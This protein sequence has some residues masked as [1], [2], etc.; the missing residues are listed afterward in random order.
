MI[1]KIMVSGYDDS[2]KFPTAAIIPQFRGGLDRDTLKKRASMFDAEYDKFERKPN[3]TYIHLISVAAGEFYG[4]NSRADFYNGDSY[5]HDFPHPE[6]GGPTFI[7]LKPGLKATH[8]KTFMENGAPY[9]EHFSSLDGAKPQGYIVKAGINENM[10]RGELII[11]V[12]TDKWSEDIHKLESGVP[13]KFS[14]GASAPYD[15]CSICGRRA[16]TEEKHCDHYKNMP[17]AILEDGNQVYVISDNCLFHDISRVKNPAEKIAFSIRKVASGDVNRFLQPI[18][19]ANKNVIRSLCKTATSKER[20]DTLCKLAAI[21]KQIIAEAKGG[22]LDPRLLKL[23][24]ERARRRR[25]KGIGKCASDNGTAALSAFLDFANEHKIID[26]CNKCDYIMSPEEFVELLVPESDRKAFRVDTDEV[27]SLL[28][29]IFEKILHSTDVDG[30]CEDNTYECDE[31]A[32]PMLQAKVKHYC[33][34]DA[35]GS[36]LDDI[37]KR[38]IYVTELTEAPSKVIITISKGVGND[39]SSTIAEDYA[40]YLVSSAKRT[41]PEQVILAMLGNIIN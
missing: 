17:G 31:P 30:F 41:T 11:G 35:D 34:S 24:K 20:F 40:S 23:F 15:I 9:T 10:H 18:G 28:P 12:E 26:A 27:R 29:G 21:E 32:S 37:V 19:P 5:R 14:I 25:N 3:H 7:I 13:M 33:D 39:I 36:T 22:T 2:G 8:N 38:L 6:K 1:N 16:T 4:P